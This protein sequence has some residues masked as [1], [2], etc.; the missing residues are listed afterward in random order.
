MDFF[1]TNSTVCGILLNWSYN[2]ETDNVLIG[3]V[4]DGKLLI[5]LE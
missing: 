1:A 3:E 2:Y 4:V 5:V